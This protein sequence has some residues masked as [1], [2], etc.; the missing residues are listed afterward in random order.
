[1]AVTKWREVR[2]YLES[3][4]EAFPT[5]EQPFGL[6]MLCFLASNRD[7]RQGRDKPLMLANVNAATPAGRQEDAHLRDILTHFPGAVHM[8][9]GRT[10]LTDRYD[11]SMSSA[12]GP[13]DLHFSRGR[14]PDIDPTRP[15]QRIIYALTST[16]GEPLEL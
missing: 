4:E 13:V 9:L 5:L 8:R 14:V 11:V 15:D 3:V 6:T 10:A 16:L 1:M 2:A 7:N 12:Q